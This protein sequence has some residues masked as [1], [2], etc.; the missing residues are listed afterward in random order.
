MKLV[1]RG[2]GAMSDNI[3]DDVLFNHT[4]ASETVS[5]LV[6]AAD[7]L[8]RASTRRA[9]QAKNAREDW[10]GATEAEFK[11]TLDPALGQAGDLAAALRRAAGRIQQAMKHATEEQQ[12]RVKVRAKL[13]A[14]GGWRPS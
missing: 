7:Q 14:R 5:A 13:L 6:G 8:D 2:D 1:E 10:S 9:A 4:V 12:Q 3:W 11:Q